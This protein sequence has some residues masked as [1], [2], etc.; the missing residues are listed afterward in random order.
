MAKLPWYFKNAKTKYN[1]NTN[2]VDLSFTISTTGKV[3]L[4]AKSIWNLLL[5]M[6]TKKPYGSW[7]FKET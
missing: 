3:F 7:R 1:P 6:T 5:T 4:M 2:T